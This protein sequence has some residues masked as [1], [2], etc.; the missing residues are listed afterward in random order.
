MFGHLHLAALIHNLSY[1]DPSKW[2]ASREVV[3]MATEGG[4]AALMLKGKLGRLAP[5]YLADIT[6]L[7]LRSPSLTPLNDAFHHL[8]YTELGH[9]VHTVIID[10]KLVM[11]AGRILTFDEAAILREVREA[12]RTR[13]HRRPFPKEWQVA[14]DRQLAYQQDIMANTV[15]SDEE[16][17]ASC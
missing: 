11:E 9:S 3:R 5:G 8:A 6:L 4:A 1:T 17:P 15:F 2:M 10:G 16:P 7:D 12:S 14:V 13:M